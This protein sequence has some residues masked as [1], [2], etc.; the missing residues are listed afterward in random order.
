[1]GTEGRIDLLRR[2]WLEAS[3]DRPSVILATA[4]RTKGS[5]MIRDLHRRSRRHWLGCAALG[6][7]ALLLGSIPSVAHA[8]PGYPAG[9]DRAIES[10]DVFYDALAADGDWIWQEQFGWVWSPDG[11]SVGWRPYSSEGRWVYTDDGWF[12]ESELPWGWATFHY[13]RWYHSPDEGW[14]WVPGREWAPAWVEWR[15]GAG[16]FGWAPLPPRARFD[17]RRGIAWQG[18]RE[19]R[20]PQAWSFV[21]ERELLEPRLSAHIEYEPLNITLLARTRPTPNGYAVVNRRIINRGPDVVEVA[22]VIGHPV[23]TLRFEEAPSYRESRREGD[24]LRVYRPRVGT[25]SGRA[26]REPPPRRGASM[27]REEFERRH[28][29]RMEQIERYE[30]DQR[31]ALA[32]RHAR[33]EREARAEQRAELVRQHEEERRE[34]EAEIARHRRAAR[35]AEERRRRAEA[36]APATPTQSRRRSERRD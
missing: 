16:Y 31:R 14:L 8:Q 26:Q 33:E 13:G 4:Y 17:P 5:I 22:R 6:S 34:E 35:A 28:R 21:P 23:R 24:T 10:N 29:E 36:A 27:S 11:V 20:E 3:P 2:R 7:A 15:H 32:E 25:F 1:M 18:A 19:V 9:R 12:W 30:A